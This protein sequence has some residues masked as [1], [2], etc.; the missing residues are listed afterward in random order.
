MLPQHLT[1]KYLPLCLLCL[2]TAIAQQPPEQTTSASAQTTI[3]PVA[4]SISVTALVQ[5]ISVGRMSSWRGI[6]LC[7]EDSAPDSG[8]SLVFEA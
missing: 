5:I 6:D 2:S 8:G 3:A 1:K 4:Q 7:S